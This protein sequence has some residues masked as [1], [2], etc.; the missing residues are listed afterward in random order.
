MDLSFILNKLV[1]RN[2]GLK[3]K[4]IKARINDTP[5]YYIKKILT[6]SFYTSISLVFIFFLF[7][8]KMP[9]IYLLISFPFLFFFFYN[10][11]LKTVDVKIKKIAAQIDKEIIY[12]GRFLIIEIDSGINL[13]NA[14]INVIKNYRF[15]GVHF[16]GISDKI[17]VGTSIEDAINEEVDIIASEN[18][19]KLMWQVLNS[20]KTGTN[21]SNALTSVVD[22]IQKEQ[23]IL[24]KE[25]GRKLNPLAMFYMMA[26]II[27]PS[28]G[29]TMLVVMTTFLGLNMSLIFLIFISFFLGFIQ[30]MFIAMVKSSR[31][32]VEL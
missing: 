17:K 23:E 26:A 7:F 32:A 6:S 18:L 15:T 13:Y 5:R 11:F 1:E 30:F 16:K 10:Y 24:V 31:P 25:Y 14:I 2:K 3:L 8:S 27:L 20:V 19:K 4:L 21:I 28:L 12:V 22:Q 9:K 29:I